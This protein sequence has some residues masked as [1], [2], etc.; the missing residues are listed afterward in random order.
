[1]SEAD[2]NHESKQQDCNHA[3]LNQELP[4]IKREVV[5][6]GNGVV[7]MRV[8]GRTRHVSRDPMSDL[9]GRFIQRD[10]QGWSTFSY[11]EVQSESP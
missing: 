9:F 5:T 10:D 6:K 7:I 1:M 3:D 4:S 8:T 11:L 2:K